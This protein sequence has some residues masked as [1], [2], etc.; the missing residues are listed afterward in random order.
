[1]VVVIA[2]GVIVFL[3]GLLKYTDRQLWMFSFLVCVVV[4]IGLNTV[5]RLLND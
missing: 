3:Y 5:Y 1:M 2:R 4:I